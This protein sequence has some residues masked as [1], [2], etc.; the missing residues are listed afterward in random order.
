MTAL[1][2]FVAVNPD[3]V[4]RGRV[5]AELDQLEA[6]A[7][8][9]RWVR[10]A[11]L[12]IT[13]VFLGDVDEER[14]PELRQILALAAGRHSTI[15]IELRGG[16]YF[17]KSKPR[18]LWAGVSGQTDDLIAIHGDVK[19]TLEVARFPTDASDRGPGEAAYVPHMTLARARTPRGEPAFMACAAAL[20][21]R[22]FG[23][24]RVEGLVLYQSEPG[25]AGPRY[26]AL[27][28]LPLIGD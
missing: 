16:G 20:A 26:S 4:V 3:D 11:A 12:H 18:T 9:A 25:A 6:L 1:R 27:A 15:N 8:N 17:G 23:R 21:S 22:E 14:V 2:L 5:G 13:L 10:R 7:P 24:I 28:I 19:A